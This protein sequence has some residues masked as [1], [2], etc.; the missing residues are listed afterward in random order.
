MAEI[1]HREF[2]YL[3][4]YFTLQLGQIFPYWVLGMVLGSAISVFAKRKRDALQRLPSNLL[5]GEAL[6][7]LP[8]KIGPGVDFHILQTNQKHFANRQPLQ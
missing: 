5:G 3:W 2:V 1:F 4:Y 8:Q 7:F 6:L